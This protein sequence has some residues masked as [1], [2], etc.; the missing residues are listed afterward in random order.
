MMS[1]YF[2][3]ANI[4]AVSRGLGA[5]YNWAIRHSHWILL[6]SVG[7]VIVY[8]LYNVVGRW[9]VICGY[10]AE[11]VANAIVKGH[12]FS[13]DGSHRWLFEEGSASEYFPTAWVDPVFTYLLAGCYWLFGEYGRLVIIVANLV[14]LTVTVVVVFYIGK[15]ITGTDGALLCA[16]LMALV[17]LLHSIGINNTP[18][19]A[20]MVSL[21]ALI[22]V[23]C[24]DQP[25]LRSAFGLGLFL[26]LTV[27][28]CPSAMLFIPVAAIVWLTARLPLTRQKIIG[29]II[30]TLAAGAVMAPW[31][32]RN[33]LIFNEF[34]PVRTG[35][36][37]LTHMGTV[38]LS[39]TFK[40]GSAKSTIPVPFTT[41]GPREAVRQITR[42]RD[43]RLA[44]L[45]YQMDILVANPP[46]GFATMNE[47]QRDAIY[48]ARAKEFV[49]EN[50]IT[51]MQLAVFKAYV[52]AR[53]LGYLGFITITF[54]LIA[55][56]LGTSD[57]RIRAL[58]LLLLAYTLPFLIIICYFSRYRLPIEPIV[59]VLVGSGI[60]LIT[61]RLTGL[62]SWNT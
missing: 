21:S 15:H 29:A 13:F 20:L 27:L 4:I 50:P 5:I 37:E 28:A 40:P 9:Q 43:A 34:V 47:A 55:G 36:G 10:E 35:V 58:F 49:L 19:A 17:W 7:L 30:V 48:L 32:I 60:I 12:G 56:A 25:T 33:Y 41:S 2:Q 24:L 59:V 44:L 1:T 14:F 39:E 11:W 22:L 6:M 46:A 3:K 26:G 16:V 62:I 42:E 53:M 18:L 8:H 31:T 38:V 45:K 54:A 52:F 51:T 23:K 57:H 61:Q